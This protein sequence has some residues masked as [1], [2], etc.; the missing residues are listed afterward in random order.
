[1][2]ALLLFI[3]T[4]TFGA[5]LAHGAGTPPFYVVDLRHTGDAMLHA[6][7]QWPLPRAGLPYVVLDK[8]AAQCCFM[9]GPRPGQRKTPLKIDEDAPPLSSEEGDETFQSIGHLTGAQAGSG[10][11]LLAFGVAGMSAVV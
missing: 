5:G 3:L 4:F 11:R 1:M 8:P 9:A 10:D 7:S 2:K 6:S